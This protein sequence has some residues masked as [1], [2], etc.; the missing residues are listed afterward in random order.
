MISSDSWKLRLVLSSLDPLCPLVGLRPPSKK[1]DSFSHTITIA[2][3]CDPV[4]N[5]IPEGVLSQCWCRGR[6]DQSRSSQ[7]Y[8]A[9]CGCHEILIALCSYQGVFCHDK[10][11]PQG[12][13]LPSLDWK[14]DLEK[15]NKLVCLSEIGSKEHIRQRSIM[16]EL[17][18]RAMITRCG[19]T[20]PWSKH[21]ETTLVV[22]EYRLRTWHL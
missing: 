7:R 13:R 12:N 1:I 3:L 11:K 9:W 14:E 6:N 22:Q 17:S 10:K 20:N 2:S 8:M 19:N 15:W 16:K 5:T 18:T 21:V 4:Q